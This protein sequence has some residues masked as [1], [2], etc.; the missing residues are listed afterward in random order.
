M[1]LMFSPKMLRSTS[2]DLLLALE[3]YEDPMPAP[4]E[5]TVADIFPPK[6]LRLRRIDLPVLAV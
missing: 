1:A 6:M 2:V 4:L 3:A 5:A